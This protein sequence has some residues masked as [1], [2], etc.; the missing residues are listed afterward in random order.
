MG[1]SKLP[2][3][4]KNKVLS[5]RMNRKD[6]FQKPHASTQTNRNCNVS[7]REN[8]AMGSKCSPIPIV[9]QTTQLCL[10]GLRDSL[11]VGWKSQ[12]AGSKKLTCQSGFKKIC[13]FQV[14]KVFVNHSQGLSLNYF[15]ELWQQRCAQSST[16]LPVGFVPKAELVSP[17][18][19]ITI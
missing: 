3:Q 14:E 16:N 11:Q 9:K 15:L 18:K 13:Y 2:N 7:V 6:M 4:S 19:K 8:P 12:E 17:S 10:R 5:D 1:P